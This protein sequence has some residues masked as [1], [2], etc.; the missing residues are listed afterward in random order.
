SF[1]SGMVPNYAFNLAMAI[2]FGILLLFNLITFAIYRQ[3][4]FG[5]AFVIATFLE[6]LGYI[7]RT[8]SH[9]ATNNMNDFLIQFI[10]LTIAPVFTMG[11][12][13]YQLAK[14]G[15]VY[16][17]HFSRLKPI[18]YS[19]VF[20]S[21][22][23]LS[24]VIQALG[25]GIAGTATANDESNTTGTHVFVGGLALQVFSMAIFLCFMFD[26]L[27]AVYIRAKK[28]LPSPDEPLESLYNPKYAYIRARPLFKYFNFAVTIA[29]LFVFVRCIY[30]VV[31]LAEG[32]SGFLM[33]H[34]TYFIILDALMMSIATTI[35]VP[36]YPGFM[37]DGRHSTIPV[38]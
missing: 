26:F 16:G 14:L 18:Y 30:R 6:M 34:E 9:S 5:T 21:C 2:I 13:Y 28:D 35:F 27:H 32:W 8:L 17:E 29:T 31:E 7:G 15:A 37:F 20:V 22:D 36:F 1:Y 3:Y 24:L 10:C 12:I 11:G 25:G 38:S 4:W 23:I 19:Y 33:T